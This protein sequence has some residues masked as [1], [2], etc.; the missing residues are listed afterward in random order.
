MLYRQHT[1]EHTPEPRFHF[2]YR[3]LYPPK[4]EYFGK[5]EA[6][7]VSIK[8][9]ANSTFAD[10]ADCVRRSPLQRPKAEAVGFLPSCQMQH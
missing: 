1:K 9:R 8:L 7:F 5:M 6:C 2:K 3:G 4:P 10:L